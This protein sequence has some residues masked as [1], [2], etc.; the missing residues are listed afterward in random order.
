ML[1]QSSKSSTGFAV[2]LFANF[3]LRSFRE[4]YVSRLESLLPYKAKLPVLSTEFYVSSPV[5]SFAVLAELRVD[6]GGILTAVSRCFVET[7]WT[8]RST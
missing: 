8:T 7:Y 2:N 4:W 6:T 1:I 3:N 5:F